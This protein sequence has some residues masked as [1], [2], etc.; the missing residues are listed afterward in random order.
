MIP[1]SDVRSTQA[2]G[3]IYTLVAKQKF[4]AEVLGRSSGQLL[5]MYKTCYGVSIF[6][7]LCE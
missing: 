2:F 6:I 7:D 4:W 1:N 3:I 5:W